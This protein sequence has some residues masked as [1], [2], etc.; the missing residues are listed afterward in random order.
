MNLSLLIGDERGHFVDDDEIL[1]VGR[2]E[3]EGLPQEG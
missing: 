3:L 1:V 2:I